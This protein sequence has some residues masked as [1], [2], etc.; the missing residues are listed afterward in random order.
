MGRESPAEGCRPPPMALVHKNILIFTPTPIPLPSPP[1]Y[2]FAS[3]LPPSALTSNAFYHLMPF[4]SA[5]RL[6]PKDFRLH[7]AYCNPPIGL[8]RAG[9][10]PCRLHPDT[11]RERRAGIVATKAGGSRRGPRLISVSSRPSDDF[12]DVGRKGLI[13][14][15]SREEGQG[16]TRKHPW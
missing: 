10:A 6:T 14:Y 7:T 2:P 15:D 12:G 11:P 4:P 9:V 13:C 3:F 8:A 1:L 5:S 16:A